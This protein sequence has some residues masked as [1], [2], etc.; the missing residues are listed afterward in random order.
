[1]RRRRRSKK[2]ALDRWQYVDIYQ[3]ALRIGDPRRRLVAATL[4]L[5]TG[6]LKMRIS[7]AI[8][9]HEGWLRRDYG[10]IQIPAFEPCMCTYCQTQASRN[11]SGEDRYDTVDERFANE[12]YRTKN[13]RMRHV[14]MAWSPRIVSAIEAY[15]DEIGVYG[16]RS[17][18]ATR[19]LKDHILPK[20]E[21]LEPGDVDWRG[22]R[23]TGDTFWAFN[24]MAPKSRAEIG[25]HREAE[26]GTYSG[27]SPVGLV[28][29]ARMATDREPLNFPQYDPVTS[30]PNPHRAEPFEDPR[31][32][33]PTENYDPF[34]QA[35]E[36]NPRT[37]KSPADTDLTKEDFDTMNAKSHQPSVKE[38]KALVQRYQS[39]LEGSISDAPE[40]T[41]KSKY[42]PDNEDE[43]GPGQAALD[44][45]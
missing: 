11:H 14:P 12:R 5:L 44:E 35:P 42:E 33:D 9:F 15:V 34:K 16:K 6:R 40:N 21:L 23:A 43:H 30:N 27:S 3:A 36:F 37:E 41:L 32:I 25:G 7:E 8:H 18:S 26:L 28:N 19:L 24:G 10:L 17:R 20:A 13:R 2:D 45:F 22:L 38:L 29:E 4:I 1:M 39:R 31:D